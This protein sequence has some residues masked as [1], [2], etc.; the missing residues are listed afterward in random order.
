MEL[1]FDKNGICYFEDYQGYPISLSQDTWQNHIL[2]PAKNRQHL[3]DNIDK[4]ADTIRHPYN[5][6]L[7]EEGAEYKIIQKKHNGYRLG[8]TLLVPMAILVVVSIPNASISTIITS[9]SL[10]S[11]IILWPQKE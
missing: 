2:L 9:T 8:A 4:I 7:E 11:G 6:V 3:T 10:R 1:I 5:V